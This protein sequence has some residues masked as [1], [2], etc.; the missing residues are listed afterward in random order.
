MLASVLCLTVSEVWSQA[1]SEQP[2]QK[3][4]EIARQAEKAFQENRLD[5]AAKLYREAVR[6]RPQWPEGWGYLAAAEFGPRTL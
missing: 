1:P 2:P 5:D 3:F 4:S 6:L